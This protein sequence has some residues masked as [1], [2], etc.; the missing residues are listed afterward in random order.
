MPTSEEVL[1]GLKVIANDWHLLS[2]MW[3]AYFAVLVLGLILGVRP[4][5]RVMGVLLA[6][7]LFSVSILAWGHS[8]PFNG[9]SFALAGIA[10]LAVAFRLGGNPVEV[11][12]P[13]LTVLGALMIGFGWVYPHFLEPASPVQYLYAAPTGLIPCP[14]LSIVIGVTL[15]LGGLRSRPWCLVL[16]TMGLFYGVLGAIWLGVSMD[17]GLFLGALVAGYAA[18]SPP[19]TGRRRQPNGP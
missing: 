11:A 14:T 10:L 19:L 6:L 13:W 15:T 16:A 9:I 18:F 4:T 2:V 7:P 5:R 3:H 17:W 12:P 1:S 8:N